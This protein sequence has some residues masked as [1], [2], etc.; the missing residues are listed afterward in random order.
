M[1]MPL[2][3]QFLRK[4]QVIRAAFMGLFRESVEELSKYSSSERYLW[5]WLRHFFSQE[6]VRGR[7][8]V[9]EVEESNHGGEA[10]LAPQ[11]SGSMTSLGCRTGIARCRHGTPPSPSLW[12]T[13]L[14]PCSSSTSPTSI[15][16]PSLCLQSV[17]LISGFRLSGSAATCQYGSIR[18]WPWVFN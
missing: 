2:I 9:G 5:F 7:L 12:R 4:G 14:L 1:D 13:R 15:I 10:A 18:R 11:Q 16:S 8:K 17:V 3:E 6:K